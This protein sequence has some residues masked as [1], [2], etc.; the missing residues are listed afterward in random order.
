MADIEG[1]VVIKLIEDK[2]SELYASLKKDGAFKNPCYSVAFFGWDEL[3]NDLD[4]TNAVSDRTGWTYD[5]GVTYEIVRNF[6]IM[7]EFIKNGILKELS[8]NLE[9]S[10]WI[11][12]SGALDNPSENVFPECSLS[13]H[14]NKMKIYEFTITKEN[15]NTNWIDDLEI[16]EDKKERLKRQ[17]AEAETKLKV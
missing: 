11:E 2:D 16:E 9:C 10:V 6:D 3:E 13:Y 12:P 7:I 14:D 4:V 1:N 15:Y 8:E 17:W 5:S